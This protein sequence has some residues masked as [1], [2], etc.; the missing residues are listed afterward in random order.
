V[1]DVFVSTLNCCGALFKGVKWLLHRPA[2][3]LSN[4]YKYL[5]YI[6]QVEFAKI[7]NETANVIKKKLKEKKEKNKLSNIV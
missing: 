7:F 3:Y 1:A 6:E 2:A 5:I 4:S